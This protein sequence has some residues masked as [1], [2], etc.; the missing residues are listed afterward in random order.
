MRS[1]WVT[2]AGLGGLPRPRPLRDTAGAG[3]QC[4]AHLGCRVH[5]DDG[6]AG[7]GGGGDGDGRADLSGN[8]PT[9]RLA[10]EGGGQQQQQQQL[11]HTR[12]RR[13]EVGRQRRRQPAIEAHVPRA[14]LKTE[15]A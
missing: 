2:T 11:Q 15:A 1:L 8:A 12:R 6:G 9:K 13:R 7:G 5:H 3:H 10:V 4:C 14:R